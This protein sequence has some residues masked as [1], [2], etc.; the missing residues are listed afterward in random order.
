MRYFHWEFDCIF[1]FLRAVVNIPVKTLK[2]SPWLVFRKM[3]FSQLKLGPSVDLPASVPN[4]QSLD[5][6][7]WHLTIA[8]HLLDYDIRRCGN[9]ALFFANFCVENNWCQSLKA[10]IAEITPKILTQIVIKR[11]DMRELWLIREI[12]ITEKGWYPNQDAL[13]PPI[14]CY[15]LI[16]T[17]PSLK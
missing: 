4:G 13:P 1:L 7:R 17:L 10:I 12:D 9:V 15:I 14:S 2:I 8:T 11:I 16:F 3:V 6:S 5:L